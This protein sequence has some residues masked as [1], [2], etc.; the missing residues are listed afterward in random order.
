MRRLSLI[1]LVLCGVLG[2]S[3]CQ[4]MMIGYPLVVD[5]VGPVDSPASTSVALATP[6]ALQP[7]LTQ[8]AC[9]TAEDGTFAPDAKHQT[10]YL[11]NAP[12]LTI[13]HLDAISVLPQDGTPYWEVDV[14]TTP[15]DSLILD[16]W[17]ADNIGVAFAMV[18]NGIAV[19][20]PTVQGALSTDEMLLTGPFSKA[21]ATTI[22]HQ[23]VG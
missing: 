15:T 1:V 9:D 21:D 14:K 12:F 11:L 19:A 2:L 13:T 3:G 10:C 23:I 4:V 8:E 5:G 18:S 7:V 20:Q 6:L 17:T 16:N 22:Q